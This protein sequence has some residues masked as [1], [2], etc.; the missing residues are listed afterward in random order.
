MPFEMGPY[1]SA[2]FLCEKVL[3]EADGVKSA[4][5]IIDRVTHRFT[6]EDATQAAEK[7]VFPLTLFIRFK[8][9]ASRGPMQLAIRLENPS[10][11]A[12]RPIDQ[13]IVFEGE[14]DRGID[15]AVNLTIEFDQGGMYWFD[16]SLEGE[17]VTRVPLRIIYMPQ[18]I[19]PGQA[20]NP[21]ADPGPPQP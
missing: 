2:A 18:T 14:D 3:K 17:R 8:A 9:G 12:L 11:E 7:F 16:V 10:G 15:V 19:R 1:L 20:R 13:T 4:I 21:N 5:R 6:R